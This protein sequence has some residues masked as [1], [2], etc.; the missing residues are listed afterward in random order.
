MCIRDSY[1]PKDKGKV[2]RAIRNLTEEFIHL[3]KKFPGWLKKKLEEWRRWFNE[4]RYH[5]G[6]ND[7]HANLYAQ[8]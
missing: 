8:L 5:R 4:K 1:Y 7:Y 2:E 3:F 6:I